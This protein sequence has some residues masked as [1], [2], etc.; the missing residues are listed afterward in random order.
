MRKEDFGYISEF[1]NGRLQ[2]EEDNDLG[3]ILTDVLKI[4][5]P[6]A[7][8]VIG[9]PGLGTA[10]G[11]MAGNLAGGLLGGGGKSKSSAPST[12][13]IAPQV[14]SQVAS[15]TASNLPQ[16]IREQVM[17]AVRD[18]QNERG[19]LADA[20]ARIAATV[21]STFMPQINTMMKAL[22]LAQTQ[23]E[24]TSEHNSI[25]AEKAYK[26]NTTRNLAILNRQLDAMRAFLKGRL[27][28]NAKIIRS[29]RA[30]NILGGDDLMNKLG[31]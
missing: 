6:I 29:R 16:M 21:N 9:G 3:N 26:E 12:Q 17:Q 18:V 1:R 25:M 28:G 10:V 4:A 7:G 23:R 24:V 20:N 2:F 30:I 13:Q 8:T 22:A 19:S 31:Q 27:G 11:G 5:G 14:A 15:E